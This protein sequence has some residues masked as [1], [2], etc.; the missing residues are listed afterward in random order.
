MAERS[1]AGLGTSLTYQ[2]GKVGTAAERTIGSLGLGGLTSPTWT[3]HGVS[4]AGQGRYTQLSGRQLFTPTGGITGTMERE[5][6]EKKR[7]YSDLLKS[8]WLSEQNV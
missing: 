3:P 5:K 4:T 1:L 7:A 8:Y 2:A 6:I